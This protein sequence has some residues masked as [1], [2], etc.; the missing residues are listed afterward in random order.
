MMNSK[1]RIGK[2]PKGPKT[3][4]VFPH[5]MERKKH[6]GVLR[7]KPLSS[8]GSKRATRVGKGTEFPFL[9]KGTTVKGTPKSKLNKKTP[10]KGQENKGLNKAK[11]SLVSK[12]KNLKARTDQQLMKLENKSAT[13]IQIWWRKVLQERNQPRQKLI[14]AKQALNELVAKRLER[15]SF[16]DPIPEEPASEVRI[17][18]SPGQA[19]EGLITADF[20]KFDLKDEKSHLS[21]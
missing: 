17:E 6:T 9:A 16:Q 19:N 13:V 7:K 1:S 12:S 11:S 4:E 15:A 5:E 20:G 10:S 2:S 14:S 3:K 18:Q 8:Y 21:R